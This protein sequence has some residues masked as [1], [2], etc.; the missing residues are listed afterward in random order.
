MEEAGAALVIKDGD[1]DSQSLLASI[2]S[3]MADPDRLA[4]MG[5]KAGQWATPKAADRIAEGIAA[6][7]IDHETLKP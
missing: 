2:E 3:M 4:H 7:M 1:F 5:Q 6:A